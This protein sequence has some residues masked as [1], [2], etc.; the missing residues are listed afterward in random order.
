MPATAIIDGVKVY[1]LRC[2]SFSETRHTC[3]LVSEKPLRFVYGTFYLT[4]GG[5]FASSSLLGG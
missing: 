4:I 2:S 5:I 1:L 3:C